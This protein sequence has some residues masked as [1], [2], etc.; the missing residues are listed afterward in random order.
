MLCLDLVL[1]VGTFPLPRP[2]DHAACALPKAKKN[3]VVA[4]APSAVFHYAETNSDET[5]SSRKTDA[6]FRAAK[7]DLLTLMKLDVSGCPP[8]FSLLG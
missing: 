7:K 4:D 8:P 2:S 5:V 1:P 6:I 3:V